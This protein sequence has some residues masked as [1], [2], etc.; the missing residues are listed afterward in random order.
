MSFPPFIA[1]FIIH[2]L[3]APKNCSCSIPLSPIFLCY[4]FYSTYRFFVL[5]LFPLRQR[6]RCLKGRGWMEQWDVTSQSRDLVDRF[7]RHVPG[8]GPLSYAIPLSLLP[9]RD[10]FHLSTR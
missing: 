6:G 8:T 10:P 4:L 5:T 2:F 7:R 1:S 3:S 9:A